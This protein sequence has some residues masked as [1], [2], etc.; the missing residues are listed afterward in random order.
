MTRKL[1]S[2]KLLTAIAAT[3][4]PLALC[5]MPREC[6]YVMD[7]WGLSPEEAGEDEDDVLGISDLP[8]LMDKMTPDMRLN[9]I[10]MFQPSLDDEND[11][12]GIQLGLRLASPD[13]VNSI[14][15]R[16]IGGGEAHS[17]LNGEAKRDGDKEEEDSEH[18]SGKEPKS[19]VIGPDFDGITILTDEDDGLC[20][21]VIHQGDNGTLPLFNL[22]SDDD[23]EVAQVTH[24][25]P[26]ETPLVGFHANES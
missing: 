20:N 19:M 6:F 2:V 18:P 7:V 11:Q 14:D 12:G 4:A 9:S 8:L 26:K 21:V 23:E 3:I 16:F 22:C 24:Y 17:W 15:L 13:Q 1:F 10:K 25:L 5:Q